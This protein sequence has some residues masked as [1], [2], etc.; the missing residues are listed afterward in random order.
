MTSLEQVIAVAEGL[1][2]LSGVEDWDTVG[3]ASGRRSDEVG[4]ILLAVD[5]VESTVH[6][7]VDSGADLLLTHHPLLLRGITSV[8][9]DRYK[10]TLL[11]TLIR[12]GCALYS[13]HTNADVTPD[14]TSATLA[15]ALGLRDSTPLVPD[16]TGLQ[17]LGRVGLL[18]APMTLGSL[19]RRVGAVL[20]ATAG[21]VRVAGDFDAIVQRIAVCAGAGDSLLSHPDVLGADVYLTSDL[22]HHPAQE[23]REN[24]RVSGGPALIDVS[25]WAS[26]WLWLDAAA[27]LLRAALPTLDIRVSELNT[28]PWD[29]LVVQ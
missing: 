1:W 11:A 9:E 8:S 4:T 14:G 16:S 25:H 28:D 2:P 3:L 20:P 17:G 27:T 29:F 19:A 7:A 23:A 21:G 15:H 18:D 22:R 5:A 12:G 26:E 6:E 10:G 13:A 24:S